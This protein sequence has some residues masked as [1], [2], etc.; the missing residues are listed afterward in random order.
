M[1]LYARY[2]GGPVVALN[3]W[4]ISTDPACIN[5]IPTYLMREQGNVKNIA[6]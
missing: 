1:S 2:N 4:W 3:C 5:K 6:K